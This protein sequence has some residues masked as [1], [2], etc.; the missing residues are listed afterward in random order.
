M[1]IAKVVVLTH[2]EGAAESCNNTKDKFGHKRQ[3]S[4]R[5]VVTEKK[6]PVQG[7]RYTASAPAVMAGPNIVDSPV[8]SNRNGSNGTIT[9][10]A[11][12]NGALDSIG[13]GMPS[14]DKLIVGVDFGTTYSG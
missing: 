10:I 5:I 7:H 1:E 6:K 13:N 11:Q 12:S 8:E 4:V 3:S 2:I 9:P 14:A